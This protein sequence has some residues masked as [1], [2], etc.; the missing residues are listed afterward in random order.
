M[1]V[2][3]LAADGFLTAQSAFLPQIPRTNPQS[4]SQ[5]HDRV[6]LHSTMV[7][8]GFLPGTTN[9]KNVSEKQSY[10]WFPHTEWTTQAAVV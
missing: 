10:M 5:T 7:R 9:F 4:V 6:S 2:L 3:P 1:F 8:A